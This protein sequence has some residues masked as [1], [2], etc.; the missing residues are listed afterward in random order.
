MRLVAPFEILWLQDW[1]VLNFFLSG[2]ELWLESFLAVHISHYLDNFFLC[3]CE[4]VDLS[5][6]R[7]F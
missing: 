7:N 4:H 2:T 6:K 3:V 1:K 5:E